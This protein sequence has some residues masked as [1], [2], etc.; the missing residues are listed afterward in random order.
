M[1]RWLLGSILVACLLVL[2]AYHAV[3]NDR[4]EA[5]PENEEVIYGATGTVSVGGTVVHSSD[6]AFT[7]RLTHGSANKVITD[8]SPMPVASGDKVEV[9]GMLKGD[10]LIPE[11]RIVSTKWTHHPCHLPAVAARARPG[12]LYFFE[13]LDL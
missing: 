6:E 7:L 2:S 3:N 8:I 5:Y 10:E 4:H 13:I 9:L 11:E 1:N 12:T